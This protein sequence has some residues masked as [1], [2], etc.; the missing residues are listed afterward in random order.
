VVTPPSLPNTAALL[1]PFSVSKHFSSS[2]GR[3]TFCLCWLAKKLYI[4]DLQLRDCFVNYGVLSWC[5]WRKN[6]CN[7][8]NKPNHY[9]RSYSGLQ[10]HKNYLK[11][12]NKKQIYRKLCGRIS[13]LHGSEAEARLLLECVPQHLEDAGGR[14]VPHLGWSRKWIFLLPRKS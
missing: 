13:E 2:L 12:Q 14:V 6:P 5:N 9:R 3:K 1:P 10:V 8:A 11:N 4:Q 7:T